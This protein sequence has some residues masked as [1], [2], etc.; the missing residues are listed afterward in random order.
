MG[1]IT[2]N[3]QNVKVAEPPE[4]PRK[5]VKSVQTADE[6]VASYPEV[7]QRE[8]GGLPGTVHFE[9]EQGI[10]LVVAPLRRVPTSLKNKLK[11]ELDRLQR[12]EVIAHISEPT[13]WLS[14]LAV[15]IK[16]LGFPAYL[17]FSSS[18]TISSSM[19]LERPMKKQPQTTKGV[20][21]ISFKGA[22]TAALSLI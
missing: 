8:L 22:R 15:A 3:P 20:S 11:E 6:L 2:V 13:P 7:F 4:R 5:E 12:L 16:K 17:V 10:T 19:A 14:S 18:L 21:K 9:V 1:L